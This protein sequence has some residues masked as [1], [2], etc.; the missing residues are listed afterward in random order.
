MTELYFS[1][2]GCS[3]HQFGSSVNGF[4]I[5]GC[6]MD[7]YLDMNLEEEVDEDRVSTKH[8]LYRNSLEHNSFIQ[9]KIASTNFHHLSEP[10]PSGKA[11]YLYRKNWQ[12]MMFHS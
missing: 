6:D 11:I 4:G 7:L 2:L 12:F 5:K 8:R 10:V 1:Y 9:K 3:L